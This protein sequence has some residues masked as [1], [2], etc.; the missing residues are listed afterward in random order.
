MPGSGSASIRIVNVTRYSVEII[1]QPDGKVI[2]SLPAPLQ[3]ETWLI[4]P[5]DEKPITLNFHNQ[6]PYTLELFWRGVAGDW[7]P[8]GELYDGQNSLLGVVQDAILEPESGKV[9]IYI[10][11]PTKGDGLVMVHL[12]AINIPKEA[13]LPGGALSLM[14]LPIRK[15]F[16]TRRA[17]QCR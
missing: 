11:K 2:D 7:I 1:R 3:G 12:R 4:S 8:F 9:G 16:G 17:H 6:T 13:L 10:I 15:Y 5:S 14:L